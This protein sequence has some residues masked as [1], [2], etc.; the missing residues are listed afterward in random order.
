[1]RIKNVGKLLKLHGMETALRNSVLRPVDNIHITL[2]WPP[3]V[4]TFWRHVGHRVLISAKGREYQKAVAA[5]VLTHG[6]RMKPGRYAVTIRAYPPDRR[7][8]DIDNLHKCL[9]D[10]LV[11][12]GVIEDDEH[13]DDLRILRRPVEKPGH[14]VVA[15]ETI[16]E[17]RG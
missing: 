14:V 12:A 15:I 6:M 11:K 3:S 4:N 1:M 16:Q 17:G 7:K 2:P 5:T 13:I 10:S 8:R 9:L